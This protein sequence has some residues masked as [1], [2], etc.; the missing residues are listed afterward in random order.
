MVRTGDWLREAWS[1]VTADIGMYILV[2][3]IVGATNGI[4]ASCDSAVRLGRGGVDGDGRVAAVG[5]AT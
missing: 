2:G 1:V 5:G 3:L 4:R